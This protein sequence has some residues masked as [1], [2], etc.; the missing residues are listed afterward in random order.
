MK[1][2]FTQLK[3]TTSLSQIVQG[4]DFCDITHSSSCNHCD[5]IRK[6]LEFIVNANSCFDLYVS[7]SQKAIQRTN[8]MLVTSLDFPTLKA[9]LCGLHGAFM[10]AVPSLWSLWTCH[11]EF[12]FKIIVSVSDTCW[13]ISGITFYF[14][15]KFVL[16]ND[17]QNSNKDNEWRRK[18]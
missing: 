8:A 15:P 12:N 11:N 14:T 10:F 3:Y 5:I 2:K 6:W 13:C 4:Q 1:L 18:K 17:M 7:I 16:M 9:I